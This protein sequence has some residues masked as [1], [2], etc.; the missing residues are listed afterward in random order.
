MNFFDSKLVQEELEEITKI[1]EEIYENVFK[2]PE[3]DTEEKLKHINLLKSLLDKQ[4][5]LYTRVSLSDDPEA[6]RLKRYIKDSAVMMGMPEDKDI[7]VIFNNMT[8]M[9]DMMRKQLIETDKNENQ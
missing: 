3:M 4:K 9:L 8:I 7:N 5:V 6:K 2:F 1:Q